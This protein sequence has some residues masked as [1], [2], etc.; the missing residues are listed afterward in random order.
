MCPPEPNI[1]ADDHYQVLGMS[2]EASDKDIGAAFKRLAL[3]YH[4][5]KNP[6]SRKQAELVFKRIT[7]SYEV[8]R[9]PVKRQSYD[10]SRQ[11]WPESGNP[12]K[13][14]LGSLERA[15]DLYQKF[16]GG[17][18]G[19]AGQ[20]TKIDVAGIFNFG[21]MPGSPTARPKTAEEG[22]PAH[23]V[24]VGTPVVIHGLTGKTEHNGKSATVLEW[25]DQKRRYEVRLKCGDVL[26]LRP[27]NITQLVNVKI[28]GHENQ[29]ELN[30]NTGE[31]VDFNAESG[32]Y[33]LLIDELAQVVELPPKNCILS[34]GTAILL[35]G[36]ADQQ[37]SGQLCSIISIDSNAGRYV[38]EC[39]SGRQLKVR[40]EKV[41]C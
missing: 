24:S 25:N 23:L 3:K 35:Q 41:L 11:S 32:C 37:L 38:V 8:L 30:G 29:P 16:F 14:D 10:R 15:E 34:C 9:D 36:L 5:D 4:P 27:Q 39:D 2:R 40:F 21:E 13:G 31:I 28:A 18:C 12:V 22:W 20:S 19:K 26:S 33:V 17:G 7:Q 1:H 6:N